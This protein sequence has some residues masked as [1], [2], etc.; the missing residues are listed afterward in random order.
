MIKIMASLDYDL[1]VRL[2]EEILK[3]RSGTNNVNG[4]IGDMEVEL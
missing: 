4:H 2:D 1:V 3:Q